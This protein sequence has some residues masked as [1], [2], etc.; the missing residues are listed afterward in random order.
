VRIA[1]PFSG[2]YVQARGDFGEI[3]HAQFL[4]HSF[5][6]WGQT[7]DLLSSLVYF[8]ST[9]NATGAACR[10]SGFVHSALSVA[11]SDGV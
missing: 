3:A 8:S 10:V 6:E 1:G 5:S 9:P 11:V 7:N 2:A 4:D